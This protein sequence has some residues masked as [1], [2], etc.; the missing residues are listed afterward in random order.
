MSLMRGGWGGS[1]VD[2]LTTNAT[3]NFLIERG[4]G[5]VL[6][7]PI[8]ARVLYKGKERRMKQQVDTGDCNSCH[9]EAGANGA[10]GRIMLP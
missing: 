10:P 7:K 1:Q 9:T 4:K 6:V 3:G 5:K 2:S 8:S